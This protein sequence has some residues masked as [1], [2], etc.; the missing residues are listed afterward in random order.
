MPSFKGLVKTDTA[1]MRDAVLNVVN[2][3]GAV[4]NVDLAVELA[5][6]V[7]GSYGDFNAVVAALVSE[8]KLVEVEYLLPPGEGRV[9][10]RVKSIYFPGHT[11][12]RVMP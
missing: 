2:R 8:G 3:R 6:L 11:D 9:E 1:L 10:G 4:K 7:P 5:T 12:V